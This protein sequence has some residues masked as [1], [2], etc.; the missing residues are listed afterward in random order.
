[1]FDVAVAGIMENLVFQDELYLRDR[2]IEYLGVD[3]D[4]VFLFVEVVAPAGD[5]RQLIDLDKFGYFQEIQT[6]TVACLD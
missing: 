4:E 1:M 3:V 2:E 6:Q 5:P